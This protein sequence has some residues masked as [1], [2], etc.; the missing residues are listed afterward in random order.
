MMKS[1]VYVRSFE[2][3]DAVLIYKWLNDDKLKE[4]SVGVN[5][6]FCM[7]E[8]LDWVKAR[9][10]DNRSQIWWAICARDTGKMI[11]YTSIVDIHYVNSVA[12]GSGILIGDPDYRDGLAWLEI[13][14]FKLE[15]VFERL[16]LNRYE[17]AAITEH[18]L[19]V[20]LAD[21]LFYK[22]E[23]IKRQAVYKNGRYYD[24]ACFALLRDEYFMHK[25]NGEYD[26]MS[27]MKRLSKYKRK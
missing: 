15:Y 3:D 10:R 20:P 12:F 17:G 13:C 25:N 16:N 9:M 26:M 6:R 4:F 14:I 24:E 27:V 7:D 21:A 1:T 8:A 2:E 19:S 18:P 11:G 5:R 23:G 22:T